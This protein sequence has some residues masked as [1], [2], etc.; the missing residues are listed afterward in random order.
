MRSLRLPNDIELPPPARQGRSR[1]PIVLV[2]CGFATGLLGASLLGARLLWPSARLLA[3]T[4]ALGRLEIAPIGERVSSASVELPSGRRILATVR[5]GR[6]EPRDLLAAGSK[7]R[8]EVTVARSGWLAWLVGSTEQVREQVSLPAARLAARILAPRSGTQVRV[9]FNRPVAVVSVQIGSG[10][11][12]RLRLAPPRATV[13]IG[14]VAAGA[15]EV[16]SVRISGVA[17]T[18]ERLPAPARVTWFAG[19]A[20]AEV[21]VSPAPERVLAPTAPIILTFSR[22]VASL[23]GARRPVIWPTANGTWHEPNA[24]TLV[25]Q[26]SGLGFPLGASVH[27]GLTRPMRV[28]AGSDPSTAR[29]LS[30]RVPGGSMRSLEGLLGRLGYLPLRWSSPAA[31]VPTSAAAL[32]AAALSRTSGRLSLGPRTP[33]G[34]RRLWAS[35]AGQAMMVRGA[36]MSFASAHGLSTSGTA[37]PALWKALLADD[38]AGRASPAGYS[39]VFVTET[40][41]ETLTL[42]HD[43]RVVLRTP[44][45]TGIPSRP[46]AL[47]TYPVYLHLSSTTMSGTNPDGS[48]YDDPG[49]PW[50]NYFNGGDAVH[51]FVRSAYGYPQSLG[52]VEVPIP[53]AARIW[54]YVQVGTLVTVAI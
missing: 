54:P 21:L 41:P 16:G 9:A 48:H 43:G 39:Y 10:P 53:T 28:L 42:W 45:N 17:Q 44:V 35:S 5:D 50:V 30:W 19:S 37:T 36:L 13:P 20:S 3:M 52:C 47:G 40:L 15:T 26:P 4:G 38:L 29:T 34:L 1:L 23:L 32:L 25:F 31:R 18:W 8:V 12:R 7:V 27:L 6:V 22:P 11:R 46:T 51:G 24:H 49:V 33:T 14:V 2:S